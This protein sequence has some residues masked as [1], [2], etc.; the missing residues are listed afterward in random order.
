M[1]RNPKSVQH[2]PSA[3]PV[4]RGPR[5]PPSPPYSPRRPPRALPGDGASLPSGREPGRGEKGTPGKQAS[6]QTPPRSCPRLATSGSSHQRAL[7]NDSRATGGGPGAGAIAQV[8][9]GPAQRGTKAS[10]PAGGESGADAAAGREGRLRA[11][12][13]REEGSSPARQRL[14]PGTSG[15]NSKAAA[16]PRVRSRLGPPRPP[17]LRGAGW[18]KCFRGRRGGG[19]VTGQVP[20][21]G[22]GTTLW[23]RWERHSSWTG[24][25]SLG[26][27]LSVRSK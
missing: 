25:I 26:L 6:G 18:M 19:V 21:E 13:R 1:D 3:A 22:E 2:S 20:E 10:R 16:A 8:A 12:S 4:P 17:S 11:G 7:Y 9:A 14:R 27:A 23:P 24:S 5:L 15:R